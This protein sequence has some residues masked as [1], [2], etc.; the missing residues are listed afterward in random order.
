MGTQKKKRPDPLKVKGRESE[1]K[2]KAARK[3]GSTDQRNGSGQEHHGAEA[4][5]ADA[6]V[7]VIQHG[8]FLD[9]LLSKTDRVTRRSA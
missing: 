6:S 8:S 7:D 4:G 1:E 5:Q 3:R 9:G 2:E